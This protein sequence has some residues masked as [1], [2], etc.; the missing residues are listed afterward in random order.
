MMVISGERWKGNEAPWNNLILIWPLEMIFLYTQS[1]LMQSNPFPQSILEQC[2]ITFFYCVHSRSCK[3]EV[4]ILMN[5]QLS[6]KTFQGLLL[7]ACHGWLGTE[8]QLSSLL[9]CKPPTTKYTHNLTVWCTTK[10]YH[11]LSHGIL[12]FLP[13]KNQLQFLRTR[14]KRPHILIFI[15]GEIS[16]QFCQGNVLPLLQGS[17]SEQACNTRAVSLSP[18]PVGLDT[19]HI[20]LST[21]SGAEGKPCSNCRFD[22]T[23][24]QSTVQCINH[25]LEST[26]VT[27]LLFWKKHTD[28]IGG[29]DVTMFDYAKHNHA[30][31]TLTALSLIPLQNDNN[32]LSNIHNYPAQ[33]TNYQSE[34][35][36]LMIIKHWVTVILV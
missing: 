3:Y 34:R 25:L 7:W 1:S 13:V 20:T 33:C 17:L 30:E 23:A 5:N 8:N 29:S 21:G 12:F 35:Q 15:T 9:T 22:P 4:T 11:H 28:C 32:Q 2:P 10:Y 6:H 36:C 27:K 16:I 14:L 26:A 19:L 18:Q 31:E 24:S